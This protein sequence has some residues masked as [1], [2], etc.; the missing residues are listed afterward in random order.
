MASPSRYLSALACQH[1]RYEQGIASPRSIPLASEV[2]A[3]VAKVRPAGA[4]LIAWA[5][6]AGDDGSVPALADAVM[7]AVAAM[8]GALVVARS[9]HLRAMARAATGEWLSARTCRHCNGR[10]E[11]HRRIH[12]IRTLV[13]C[14]VCDGTGERVV[15]WA[16]RARACG[17][18]RRTLGETYRT[19]YLAM[20]A[21][22]DRW[23][24]ALRAQIRMQIAPDGV[25]EGT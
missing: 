5:R 25:L 1:Q 12:G 10:G 24:R 7:I 19:V 14:R 2:A 15:S 9:H 3:S 21:M 13:R 18:P 16:A 23:D 6:Y 8:P 20:L 17:V 4:Q 22:L 11:G